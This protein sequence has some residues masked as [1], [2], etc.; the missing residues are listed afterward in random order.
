MRHTLTPGRSIIDA[1]DR[2]G[3]ALGYSVTREHVVGRMAAV[4][5]SWTAADYND[6]P[7]FVFEVESTASAGLA[8]NALKVFGR[9]LE[10][11]YKPLFFFHLVVAASRENERVLNAQQAWGSH[12]YRVYRLSDA[13]QRTAIVADVLRQ[14]RRVSNRIDVLS[15]VDALQH[16]GWGGRDV[17]EQML[18]LMVELGFNAPFLHAF[19]HLAST[20]LAYLPHFAQRVRQLDAM[21]AAPSREGY[22]GG[23]GDYIPGLIER[24]LVIA[25]GV[26]PD[27][28][29]IHI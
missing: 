3:A 18:S 27:L 14:H 6:I 1:L 15:V 9:P 7:L 21:D 17:V 24:A 11:L 5:L 28:S 2:L 4:D 10:S 13:A 22:R 12:N 23:P 19:A 20:D 8:N 29:L 26:L 25:A 16:D